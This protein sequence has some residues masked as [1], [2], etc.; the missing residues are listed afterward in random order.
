MLSVSDR[1]GAV[2]FRVHQVHLQL[3]NC[4][5]PTQACPLSQGMIV[6]LVLSH[7]V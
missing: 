3:N 6:S 2:G 4:L 1:G 7:N 5:L